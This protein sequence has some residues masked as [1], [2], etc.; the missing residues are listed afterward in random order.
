[1][2]SPDVISGHAGIASHASDLVIAYDN[3]K[4][5]RAC[6]FGCPV[7]RRELTERPGTVTHLWLENAPRLREA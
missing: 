5:G 1:M 3:G 4:S 7:A 6:E 2:N